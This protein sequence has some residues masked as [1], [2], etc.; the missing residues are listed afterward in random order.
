MPQGQAGKVHDVLRLSLAPVLRD[1]AASGVPMPDIRDK[2]WTRQSHI[3]SAM[4]WSRT[5]GGTG[6]QVD[7]TAS[8]PD[9]VA[10]VADQVQEWVIEELWGHAPTNW[11]VCPGHPA[12]HPLSAGT[13][14]DVAAWVCPHDGT[15][16]AAI[17][18]LPATGAVPATG[19][20]P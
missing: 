3:A 18:A 8:E 5:G 7:L 6:V 16:V 2:V 19:A 11:P 20:L 15:R 4:M 17:G 9:R 10:H 1:V 13:A 12:T 14:G